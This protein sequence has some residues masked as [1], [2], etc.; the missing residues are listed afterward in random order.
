[1]IFIF[2]FRKSIIVSFF[3]CGLL[4]LLKDIDLP[5]LPEIIAYFKQGW[6]FW[7][8]QSKN[9]SLSGPVGS[10]KKKKIKISYKKVSF[11][12]TKKKKQKKKKKLKFNNVVKILLLFY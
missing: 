12:K 1:M 10:V 2:S 4:Q 9:F 7:S 8:N 3:V 5:Y 11:P 6:A